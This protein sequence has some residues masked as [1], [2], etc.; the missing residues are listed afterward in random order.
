[1]PWPASFRKL[2]TTGAAQ[3]AAMLDRRR[4]R[5]FAARVVDPGRVAVF[6]RREIITLQ[7]GDSPIETA[8]TSAWNLRQ[9]RFSGTAKGFAIGWRKRA[10]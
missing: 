1:M 7:A 8:F 6:G 9:R 5:Q 10:S 3:V 2:K 4:A